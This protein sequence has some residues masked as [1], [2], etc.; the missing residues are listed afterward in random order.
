MS[1]SSASSNSFGVA[2]AFLIL[3]IGLGNPLQQMWKYLKVSEVQGKL[4]E[5]CTGE[6]QISGDRGQRD[7]SVT[8]YY[9]VFEYWVHGTKYTQVIQNKTGLSMKR[10]C[11]DDDYYRPRDVAIEYWSQ[12]PEYSDVAGGYIISPG[13]RLILFLIWGGFFYYIISFLYQKYFKKHDEAAD[14]FVWKNSDQYQ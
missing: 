14:H 13:R 7:G 6:I 2:M 5:Y 8:I 1:R 10:L 12:H 9:Y 3:G 11:K 4:L